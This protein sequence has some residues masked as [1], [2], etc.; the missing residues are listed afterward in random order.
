L[1]GSKYPTFSQALP[2]LRRLK[3]F[4]EKAQDRLF[5]VETDVQPIKEFIDKY[6]E[7]EFFHLVLIDLKACC[8]VLLNKFKSRFTGLN[9]EI[10]W[11]TFLDPRS[12]KMNDLSENEY[13]R[14]KHF[15]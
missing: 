6:C 5:T 8:R 7:E 12:R 10:L 15:L 4:L 13:E 1:S 2:Y 11:V 3:I 14:A 9:T